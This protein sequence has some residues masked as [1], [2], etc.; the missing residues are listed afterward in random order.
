[1]VDFGL[2]NI[3]SVTYF[4]DDAFAIYLYVNLQIDIPNTLPEQK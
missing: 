2:Y 1:M 4:W 3:S